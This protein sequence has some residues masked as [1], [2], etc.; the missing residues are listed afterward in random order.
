MRHCPAGGGDCQ[1]FWLSP[2][3]STPCSGG[4][5]EIADLIFQ[6]SDLKFQMSDFSFELSAF[7]SPLL[8]SIV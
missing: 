7:A 3:P 6:I 4:G 5:V 2:V 1:L 8:A